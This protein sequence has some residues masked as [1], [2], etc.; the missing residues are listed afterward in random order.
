VGWND[1]VVVTMS[2]FGRTSV[3]NESQG[4]DHGEAS[5]MYV[6]AAA[7]TAAFIGCDIN[8][9]SKLGGPNWAIGNG[10]KNGALY[11]ADTMCGYLAPH[12]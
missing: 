3:E 5:V 8:N 10:A 4:T 2:E 11:S 9:N 6:A 12:D 1:V 7:S